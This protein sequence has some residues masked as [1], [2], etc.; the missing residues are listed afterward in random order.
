MFNVGFITSEKWAKRSRISTLVFLLIFPLILILDSCG[1]EDAT[2]DNLVFEVVDSLLAPA[3]DVKSAGMSFRPPAG[4]RATGDSLREALAATLHENMSEATNIDFAELFYSEQYGSA[5][6]VSIARGLN[7]H[8]DT[9]SFASRY[10]QALAEFYDEESIVCG[11]FWAN[12]VYVKNHLIED[13]FAVHFN[14]ICLSDNRDGV[15]LEYIVARPYYTKLLK[16]LES[17]MGSIN[18]IHQGGE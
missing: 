12:D 10:R 18:L 5:V 13:S 7:L 17:S 2:A 6:I 3:F 4:F 16:S 9:A 1:N 14:L 11:D 15:E 8:S